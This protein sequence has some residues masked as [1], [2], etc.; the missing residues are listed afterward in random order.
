MKK[1]KVALGSDHGGAA[2][3]KAANDIIAKEFSNIEFVDMGGA[4]GVS[5][6]YPDMA[7]SVA[8]KVAAG[9]FKYGILFCGTGQGMAIA[10]NK[11][12]GI[13]AACVTDP[14]V[15]RFVREHN[16]ANILA[17]GGRITGIEV[18]VEIIR[19]F[20]RTDFAG[21]RHKKRVDKIN[22]YEKR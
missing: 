19:V 9:E 3:K 4:E 20:L 11:V 5:S 10:A 22:E 14:V 21:D 15:A 17:L 13:R 2:L 18:A 16:D 12:E 1:V 7:L 6:D 8:G